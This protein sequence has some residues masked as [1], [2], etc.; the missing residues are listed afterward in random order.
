MG[1]ASKEAVTRATTKYI[2]KTRQVMIRLN[3]D[4]DADMIA[5]LEKQES[6]NAYIKELIRM[7]MNKG[8]R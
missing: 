2:K 6:M 3:P 7:D 5:W 8:I 4:T 1:K